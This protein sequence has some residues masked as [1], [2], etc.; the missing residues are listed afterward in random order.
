MKQRAKPVP[1]GFR[2]LVLI[3]PLLISCVFPSAVFAWSSAGHEVI[4]AI[5]W[6]ELP[7]KTKNK[8]FEILKAHPDFAKWRD[9]FQGGSDA[10]DLPAFV[11]IRASTWPD[12][13]RRRQ[14]PYDHPNWHYVDWPLHAPSYRLG[15]EPDPTNNVLYGIAQSQKVLANSKAS[16]EDRAAHLSWILHLCGDIAQPLHCVS[17]FNDA[18]PEGDKGGNEF[19]VKPAGRGIRLHSLWDG[20]LGTSGKAQQH[21]NEAVRIA[22]E[23]PRK[24]LRELK[25][26]KTPREWSLEGR[27][28]A[29][30][31]V[32]LRGK[33]RG[34]TS[35][36][37]AAPLPE[38][39]TKEA[40]EIAEQQAA[41]AGYRLADQLRHVIR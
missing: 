34:G 36:E 39:Y 35:S 27:T 18:Y 41:K 13:I 26:H 2:L 5:A 7:A 33:L 3:V 22:T 4:A 37:T 11:F 31:K 28:L 8:T 12:T 25:K 19:F 40:K 17:L 32:Y 9:S 15:N 1:S 29:I 30:E 20:L 24:S 14:N 16:P 38:G 6:R 10:V 21:F 23:H